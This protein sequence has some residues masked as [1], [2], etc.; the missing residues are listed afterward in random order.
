MQGMP[1]AMPGGGAPAPPPAAAGSAPPAGGTPQDASQAFGAQQMPTPNQPTT[2]E[3]MQNQASTIAQQAMGL[4]EGQRKSYLIQLRKENPVMADLVQSQLDDIRNQA[5]L[6]GG[7]MLMQQQQ[8]AT[9][10]QPQ[11]L[12][13]Q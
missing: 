1:G 3:E 5:R 8:Q 6:Q 4:P 10:Q 2:V 9:Q 13:Q 7:D 11:A 12:P